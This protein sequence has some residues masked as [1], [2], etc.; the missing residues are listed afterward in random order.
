MQIYHSFHT[1]LTGG[2]N[3]FILKYSSLIK[4]AESSVRVREQ[5]CI[6]HTFQ[7]LSTDRTFLSPRYLDGR[8]GPGT[9]HC[10]IAKM[11]CS[12]YLWPDTNPLA[13]W[14]FS[15]VL[16]LFIIFSCHSE[17]TQ[18]LNHKRW[19]TE[20]EKKAVNKFVCSVS[21]FEENIFSLANWCLIIYSFMAL[22]RY[23]RSET[24]DVLWIEVSKDNL[25]PQ[26]D[27]T[28]REVS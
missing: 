15:E 18:L 28:N 5:A 24:V 25:H 8:D 9:T 10:R 12:N 11:N 16:F 19:K 26:I 14:I 13:V 22:V 6:L 1:N 21:I 20:E 7:H 27:T 17:Y 2:L 4:F 23:P 3:L